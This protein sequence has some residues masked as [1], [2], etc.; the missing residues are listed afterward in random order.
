LSI[1]DQKSVLYE[2]YLPQTYTRRLYDEGVPLLALAE[3]LRLRCRRSYHGSPLDGSPAEHVP[4]RTVFMAE[5][6]HVLKWDD[7][8]LFFASLQSGTI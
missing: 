8:A 4:D 7:D 1:G 6:H 5:P 2:I 3:P